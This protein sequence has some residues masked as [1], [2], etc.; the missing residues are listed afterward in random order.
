MPHGLGKVPGGDPVLSKI[1]AIRRSVRAWTIGWGYLWTALLMAGLIFAGVLLDHI[2]ALPRS[3]R[4]AFFRTFMLVLAGAVSVATLFPF[5]KRMGRL[6]IARRMEARRPELKNALISYLQCRDDPGT[7]DEI[8]R[9]LRQKA[10][11]SVRSLGTSVVVDSSRFVRLSMAVGGVV[12][13]FL[14]YGMVSP[15]SAAVSVERLLRPT[16]DILAPTGTHVTTVEPGELYAIAGDEPRI[17]VVVEGVRPAAACVVW[18]GTTFHDSRILL[19]RKDEGR[20]E[21]SFPPVLENGSY[22]VVA[23]DA[24]RERYGI[25]VLPAPAVTELRLTL[26]PP[27][28]TGLPARTVTDGNLDVPA[29]TAVSVHAVTNLPPQTG[30]V[31]FDSGRRVW[32]Q[33]VEGQSALG[34]QFA[35]VRSDAYVVRFESVRYPNG[36]TFKNLTP[37]KFTLTCRDDQAPVVNLLGPEDGLK[38]LASDK[39]AVTY[40]ARDDYRIARVRLRY[41]VNDLVAQPFTVAEPAVA[42]VENAAYEWD[43]STTSALPGGV[44]TY[45]LEAED[46]RPG[47]SQVGR[48][49]TRRIYL[50]APQAAGRP[51][52]AAENARSAQGQA[53]AAPEQPEPANTPKPAPESQGGPPPA[54]SAVQ[55]DEAKKQEE[56]RAL[57]DYARKVAEQ[58]RQRE[59][60]QAAN[61]PDQRPAAPAE[62]KEAAPQPPAQPVSENPAGQTP[63]A[64]P[65]PSPSAPEDR[66]PPEPPAPKD[67]SQ[68]PVRTGPAPEQAAQKGGL[69][70]PGEAKG[71]EAAGQADVGARSPGDRPGRE[72]EA[73]AGKQAQTPQPGGSAVGGQGNQ[74][75]K[76]SEPG[77]PEAAGAK[78]PAHPDSTGAAQQ[79]G[80]KAAP[81]ETAESLPAGGAEATGETRPASSPATAAEAAAVTAQAGER[82]AGPTEGAVPAAGETQAAPAAGDQT[83]EGAAT[84]RPGAAGSS[85]SSAGS[86]EGTE[87]SAGASSRAGAEGARQGQGADASG[88]AVQPGAE[89]GAQGGA[90]TG[91]P[92]GQGTRQGTGVAGD[93]TS[94]GGA[95]GGSAGRASPPA[96]QANGPVAPG[97]ARGTGVRTLPPSGPREGPLSRRDL[98]SAV[99]EV[100]RMIEENRLP[101]DLLQDLG[102]NREKLQDFVDRYRREREA[103]SPNAGQPEAAEETGQGAAEGRVEATKAAQEGVSARDA[104]P[105]ASDKDTLRNRFEGADERLSSRYREVVDRYYKVLSEER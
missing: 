21:G 1:D 25:T 77:A 78:G 49:Q 76:E 42:K 20:W 47:L 6:Y 86:R 55:R 93:T 57:Q 29:G 105:T 91:Q 82:Q 11:A 66:R 30:V 52:P 36:A 13:A 98:D 41:A 35:A 88:G 53:G 17:R 27:A 96:P 23:G 24:P 72:H 40:S 99:D 12:L 68:H 84:G 2:F 56:Q 65:R 60:E 95:P 33:P 58:L 61:P 43:L 38:A 54:Q 79:A 10:L 103:A 37:V 26:T 71:Q 44:L 64:Q 48:S 8:K 22:Y 83:A 19:T 90:T 100:G 63:P 67:T 104:L 15:K 94:D 97:G 74:R 89:R 92:Q 102:T 31:E 59:E 45:Y 9:L 101:P 75:A 70:A 7:P 16:A 81:S 85:A 14:L 73:D 3:G 50:V 34:G 62:N 5:V 32:L 80:G 18:D 87:R 4:L 46:N 51:A 28:Y 39:V 69:L